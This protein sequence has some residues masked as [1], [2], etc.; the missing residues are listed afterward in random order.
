MGKESISEPLSSYA[1]SPTLMGHACKSKK[2]LFPFMISLLGCSWPAAAALSP[3]VVSLHDFL[4]GLLLAAAAALSPKLVS[5]HDFLS[6]LL[7][8]AAAALS[9]SLSPF[10]ISFLGCL[11]LAA[12][13]ALSPSLSPFMVSFL[14]CSWLP[15]PSCLPA[16]LPFKNAL[17]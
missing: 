8:A 12:A 11:L 2:S 16:C 15:L 9:P 13:D 6:G 1:P 3:K 17:C 10:M 14:G 5:L 7:L 4:S